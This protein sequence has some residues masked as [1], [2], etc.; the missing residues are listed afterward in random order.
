MIFLLVLWLFVVQ[1]VHAQNV[2]SQYQI[3]GQIQDGDLIC[4]EGGVYKACA[5]SYDQGIYG[6]YIEN[7]PIVMENLDLKAGKT[8]ATAG[9]VTVRVSG[10]IKKGDFITSSTTA[11][12]GQKA[13]ISGFVLGVAQ[14][15]LSGGE[16]KILVAIGPK[17]ALIISSA[18]TNLLQTIK[19]AL[20]SPTLTPLASLRY[21]LAAIIAAAA[22]I[23]GFWY[24]G[25]VAKS[26]IEALGRN[27]MAGRMIQLGVVFNLF[28]TILIMASGLL[29]AYLILVL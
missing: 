6:V 27:P 11:G 4:S 21:L 10:S 17:P 7:P 24:F 14:E 3:E 15:D 8:I 13:T 9:K 5:Q 2:P 20:Q 16:G 1:P 28:L 26:G 25:R 12:V 22:F 18:K 19:E 29:I 23:L